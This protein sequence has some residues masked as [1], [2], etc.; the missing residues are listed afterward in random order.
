MCGACPSADGEALDPGATKEWPWAAT[1]LVDSGDVSKGTGC[2]SR[3]DLP[4]GLYRFSIALFASTADATAQAPVL[5]NAA[6]DFELP[7]ADDV[8]DIETD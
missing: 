6:A 8:V 2:K 3:S 5:R 1:V 7:A 4:A